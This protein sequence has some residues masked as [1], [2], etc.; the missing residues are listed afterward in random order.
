[1]A[2]PAQ[3][4]D[5]QSVCPK[6]PS[7]R[8]QTPTSTDVPP[9]SP[10]KSKQH[11]MDETTTRLTGVTL[12]SPRVVASNQTMSPGK[13]KETCKYC[14]KEVELLLSH[15]KRSKGA[16]GTPEEIKALEAEARERKKVQNRGHSKEYY[17]KHT[18]EKKSASPGKPMFK[19]K[20]CGKLV[21]LLLSHYKRSDG[22][23]GTPDDIKA[24]EA[25][26]RERK[27]E[28]N[29]GHSKEYYK[30]HTP[31]KKEAMTTYNEKHREDIRGAMASTYVESMADSRA[32]FKCPICEATF[33]YKKTMERHMAAQHS[34]NPMRISCDICEK[35]FDYPDNLS[36]HMREVHGGAK[37]KC[38]KCPAAFTR[39]KELEKHIEASWHYLEFKCGLCSKNL[40]FKSLA[41][42]IRHVIAKRPEEE[43]EHS[44]PDHKGEKVIWKKSG[45]L[46]T[47][48]SG[49]GNIQV[50]EG[51]RLLSKSVKRR[52]RR[53]CH[54]ALERKGSIY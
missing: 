49:E 52:K 23:C 30:K 12:R 28:Q 26:A 41:G 38:D 33:F 24:L 25:E 13:P 32:D 50:E 42:L 18:P 3:A 11:P 29:R 9:K 2:T 20:Y 39:G 48:T 43:T 4:K 40:V 53:G 45:I 17:K 35:V 1:M 6:S 21:E 46:L 27:M 54:E 10:W 44:H 14:S 5:Q 37:H 15:F 47:C 51:Q 16:C 34:Q 8:K 36:R 22:K 7:K 19:C 31:E